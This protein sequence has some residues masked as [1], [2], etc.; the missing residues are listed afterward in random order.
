[1]DP[2]QSQLLVVNDLQL[3][4]TYQCTSQ[5][6]SVWLALEL[7]FLAVNLVWGVFVIY[8]TW[9]FQQKVAVVETKWVLIA[10]YD[11]ILNGAVVIP[12]L[13]T[14]TNFND[15]I[16]SLAMVISIDFSA[17]GIIL[18]VLG[19]T[20][21]SALWGSSAQSGTGMISG[22]SRTAA[23]SGS[24]RLEDPTKDVELVSSE[25]PQAT[26]KEIQS[27]VNPRPLGESSPSGE[28][29]RLSVVHSVSDPEN[30]RNELPSSLSGSRPDLGKDS[31]EELEWNR[32]PV[33]AS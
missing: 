3:L 10:L 12:F 31:T 14:S 7:I 32:N 16:L 33:V 8:E 15:D 21:L 17:G 25:S 22:G 1:V 13:A 18:A 19:P 11:V 6:L 24:K 30:N 4:G 2:Y 23:V 28:D 29:H 20:T 26:N 5:Y 9:S 27:L